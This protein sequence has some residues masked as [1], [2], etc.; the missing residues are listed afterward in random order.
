MIS[1]RSTCKLYVLLLELYK[2]FFCVKKKKSERAKKE[3]RNK[4]RERGREQ[5][6]LLQ[7]LNRIVCLRSGAQPPSCAGGGRKGSFSLTVTSWWRHCCRLF[8]VAEFRQLRGS[9]AVSTLNLERRNVSL[10]HTHS[11]TLT[12]THFTPADDVTLELPAALRSS[13]RNPGLGFLLAVPGV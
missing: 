13:G 12:S 3:E 10:T 4:A 2:E 1:N 5:A 9:P 7:I 6:I 8:S 11:H